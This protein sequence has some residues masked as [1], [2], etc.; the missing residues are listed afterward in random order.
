MNKTTHI[1]LLPDE[2]ADIRQEIA[3]LITEP[4]KWL[5]HPND[6][7]GGQK[8]KDLIGTELEQHLRDLLRAIRYGMFT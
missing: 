3:D 6:Q 1:T 5:D 7:L 2:K 4:D 8:P